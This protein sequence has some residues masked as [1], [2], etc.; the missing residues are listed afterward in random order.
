MRFGVGR[1]FFDWLFARTR[2]KSAGIEKYEALGLTLF[3]AIP[4]PM[5]GA[6]TGAMA[7]FLMGIPFWKSLL[8]NLLGVLLAGGI[9]TLLS[10]LGWW[11]AALALVGLFAM[12]AVSVAQTLRT[13]RKA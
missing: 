7:G 13:R 2:R 9:M 8:C 3:V 1:R 12:A 5:T 6:W 10:L 4:L 11:G